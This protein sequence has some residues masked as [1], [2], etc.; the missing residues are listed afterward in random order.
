M[1]SIAF[2]PQSAISM[3]H[4]AQFINGLGPV[5]SKS[6]TFGWRGKPYVK[7]NGFTYPSL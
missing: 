4:Q 6:I 1:I 5:F 2:A 7:V 3:V